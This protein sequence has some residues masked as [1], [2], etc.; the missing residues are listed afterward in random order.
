MENFLKLYF[1]IVAASTQEYSSF[2]HT[3]LDTTLDLS[4]KA[5]KRSLA[6][7]DHVAEARLLPRTPQKHGHEELPHT[8]GQSSS[9]EKQPHTRG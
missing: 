1:P 6:A 3:T 2:L 8:R 7:T 4:Q 5:E 9:Q